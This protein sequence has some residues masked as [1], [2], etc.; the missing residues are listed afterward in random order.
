M[1]KIE[2]DIE[3]N[4]QERLDL[5]LSNRI[6]ILSRN[7]I[8]NLIKNGDI[9]VNGNKKKSKY[10]LRDLDK[11]IINIPEIKKIEILP[12]NIDL[13]IVYEDGDLAIINKKEGLLV[14][15]T[16]RNNKAT[17][18]NALLYHFDKLSDLG[19]YIRPGIVHRLDR[20]TSGLLIVAK[21]NFAHKKLAE[22]F[23]NRNILREYILLV[24]GLV[25]KDKGI[26]DEPIGR[27]PN[28]R[29]T[30][31]VTNKNSRRAITYYEVLERFENYTLVKARLE[32]GRTHQIRVHFSYM[33][34]EVIGDSIY[35]K[36]NKFKST[37]QLLHAIKIGFNHP[38]TNQYIEF[39][40]GIPDRFYEI[41]EK[42]K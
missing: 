16:S 42:I 37:N 7:Q 39:N 19:G 12:E 18:V 15:P 24:K 31:M 30:R 29:L 20:D 10:L 2:I 33:N 21:N 6:E 23:K 36:D 22:D 41:I 28:D 40:T 32:T 3:G 25:E 34:H 13:N 9:L 38:R 8:Q 1:K 17:L 11:I 14:H 35:S 4:V 5:Y 26:I 27:N